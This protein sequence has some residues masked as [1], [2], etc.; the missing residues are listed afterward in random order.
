MPIICVLVCERGGGS[1]FFH[2]RGSW[3]VDLLFTET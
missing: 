3:D 2:P 1:V